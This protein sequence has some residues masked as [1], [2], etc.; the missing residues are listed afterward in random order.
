M[1]LNQVLAAVR[2][3]NLDLPAGRSSR[4]ATSHPARARAI[5]HVDQIRETV[6]AMREGAVTIGQIAEVLDTH[7]KESS[8]ERINGQARRPRRHPEAVGREYR[9][10]VQRHPQGSGGGQPH[11]PDR[12]DRCSNQGNFIERSINNV[13]QSV[14]YGGGLAVFVL[15]FFL[16]NFRS[17]VVI[18]LAI[19]IS[20][21]AT[22]ALVYFGGFT[23]NLMTLG[24][25]ALGVGMM[26]DNS[27]V[28]LENIFR[29]RDEL[30]EDKRA[31]A[32]RGAGEVATAIVA[33]TITTLVI[34][35]PMIFVQGVSGIL[36]Q[37]LAYVIVF[38]LVCSLLVSLSLVP[39][40]ASKLVESPEELHKKH[41][42]Q[43]SLIGGVS[44]ASELAL[45][46]LD[47]AY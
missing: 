14:L 43:F 32:V 36:F 13:A 1:P 2:N 26:V 39:M 17:T 27:I 5:R 23:L 38:S 37:E 35:L 46:K 41:K 30:H 47:S 8:I 16:R 33:S 42:A 11:F 25:L 3:A 18:S 29:R 15:L 24:G 40:L 4:A 7:E 19:P 9:R 34:F 12:G 21:I 45:R 22:F 28:V 6:V 31:A 44:D 10:S 20:V